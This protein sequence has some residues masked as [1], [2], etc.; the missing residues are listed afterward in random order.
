VR[1]LSV[2]VLLSLAA[3]NTT[4]KPAGFDPNYCPKVA[5]WD[6]AWVELEDQVTAL[7]NQR[8][9]EGGL[10]GGESFEP[11]ARLALRTELRC[12]ARSQSRDMA[13]RGFFDHVNPDGDDVS[14]R[15]ER[16]GFQWIAVG[17][18]IAEGQPTPA[19]VMAD[20]MA[21]P[22]DCA[23]ILAPHCELLGVGY[24]ASDR[25]FWTQVFGTEE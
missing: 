13:T 10:C 16:A 1:W 7:V 2:A 19:E 23:N 11:S 18:N 4:E 24:F 17:E 12:A 8:R 3:C 21:S 22:G 6:P 20:W 9:S 25:P 5:D 14:D 15:V